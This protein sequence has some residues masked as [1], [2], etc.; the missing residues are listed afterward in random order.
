MTRYVLTRP[1]LNVTVS[2]SSIPQTSGGLLVSVPADQA[3]GLLSAL[4]DAGEAGA[5]VI[6]CARPLDGAAQIVFA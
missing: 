4:N 2:Y 3:R 1:Q 6:G 5:R